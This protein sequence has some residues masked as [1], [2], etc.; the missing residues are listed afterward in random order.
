MNNMDEQYNHNWPSYMPEK[1][2]V[3]TAVSIFYHAGWK[4]DDYDVMG[5]K[6]DA[7]Q[8]LYDELC[9]RVGI[10]EAYDMIFHAPGMDQ[11]LVDKFMELVE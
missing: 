1:A 9:E 3:L 7:M 11:D 5:K 10:Y 6:M 8:T 4:D 2:L